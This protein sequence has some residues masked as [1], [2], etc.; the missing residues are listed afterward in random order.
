MRASRSRF[1]S[2]LAI[3][4]RR[5]GHAARAFTG[6]ALALASLVPASAQI[7][8]SSANNLITAGLNGS[9]SFTCSL[10]ALNNGFTIEAWVRPTTHTGYSRIADIGS[11]YSQNVNLCVSQWTTGRPLLTINQGGTG[12]LWLEAPNAV[13]LSTWS[14]I[15]G[16]VNADRSAQLYI[17]GQ[18]VASGTASALPP[19]TAATSSFIGRA[20]NDVDPILDGA[21]ADV[22]VWTTARTQAQIQANM[23]VGSITGATT[24]LA[25]AYPFGSTGVAVLT[26]ISGAGRNLTQ[27][28]TVTY[29]KSGTGTVTTQGLAGT[30]VLTVS[31]GTLNF[32]TTQFHT[33]G[34]F[35]NGGTLQLA[36][37][38]T[39]VG[40]IRGDVTVGA[41]GRFLLQG[42]NALGWGP[43]VRVTTLNINGGLVESTAPGDQGWGLAYRLTGGELRSN[44]GVPSTSSNSRFSMGGGSSIT[45]LASPTTAL[46]S[47]SIRIRNDNPNNVLPIDVADGA[48]SPD[49][50]ISAGI[51][52]QGVTGGITK[53]GAGLLALTGPASYSGITTISAGTLQVGNGGTT[54]SLGSGN[55]VNNASLVFNRSDNI[56]VANTISGTG[57]VTKNGAGSL[58]LNTTQTYTGGTFINGGTLQLAAGGVGTGLIR[59]NVTVASGARLLM[60]AANAFGWD[61]GVKVNAV[62]ING[63]LVENSAA[64][65]NG[66]GITYQMTGGELRSAGGVGDLAS[67][68]SMGG[69]TTITT[70]ASESPATISGLVRLREGNPNNVLPIDVA[71]GAASPDLVISASIEQVGAVVGITKTG[72]GLLALAGP[73]SYGGTTTISAGTLQV[74]NGGTTGSLG[75]GN[76][77]NNA[78]L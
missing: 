47:G 21:L 71:D 5:L 20:R 27:S 18:L 19:A 46:I 30:S 15:A 60:S 43:G 28:G 13:P 14:H 17:N 45:S 62:T 64:G 55:V 72:A 53:T 77:V 42:M 69:G 75:S 74:G 51:V 58:F 48:A 26:D 1:A 57:S 3:G 10:P 2:T 31:D 68:Y 32:N 44:G 63:G 38:G 61:T 29:E 33:G 65:G 39:D 24:G 67:H 40:L 59:G 35:I 56:S 70:L 16:V 22:R 50:L 66:W 8:T 25:A 9:G 78:I 7:T 54:G 34:T 4:L 6:L 12:V 11:S 76:V 52:E 37:D 73:A 36:V 23:P 49:L 41:Q